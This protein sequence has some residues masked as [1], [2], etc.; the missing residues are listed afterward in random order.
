[1]T[2]RAGPQRLRRFI[3]AALATAT[4]LALTHGF[5]LLAVEHDAAGALLSPAGF[6][7]PLAWL[8]AGAFA[9]GRLSGAAAFCLTL[10]LGA[11]DL[12]GWAG[13]WVTR[14]LARLRRR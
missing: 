8:I 3:L 6:S 2:R 13:S 12:T 11:A 7:D 4:L 9:L 5:A 1:M 14:A 10:A